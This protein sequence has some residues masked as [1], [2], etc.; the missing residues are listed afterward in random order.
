MNSIFISGI[1]LVTPLGN[2]REKTWS[3]LLANKSA[4]RTGEA[5]MEARVID[6][7]LNG[8]RSRMGDF[9]LLAAQDALD[10]AGFTDEDLRSIRVGCAVSQSKPL[11]DSMD[12]SLV[13]SSFFGWSA[14]HVIRRRYGF[15]GPFT[16]V[17][18]ACATGVASIE[19]GAAWISSGQCDVV[20]VGA[21]ESSLNNFYRSGFEKMGVLASQESGHLPRPFDHRR[22]GF[23][24]GEGAAVMVLES[25]ASLKRRGHPA[26]ASLKSVTLQHSVSDAIRFDAEGSAVSRLVRTACSGVT[27][28]YINAHGT[29]TLFNDLAETLGLKKAFGDLAYKIPISSTKAATGHLLGA[30][31]AVEAAF[32]VLALRDQKIPPTLNLTTPDP[33][34]DLDYVPHTSRSAQVD[35]AL[36]LSYGFGGQLGAVL[37]E[38]VS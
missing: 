33:Q 15:E 38:R 21:C 35:T 20:L 26:L 30:A 25:E 31:G 4:V 14:G 19:C 22:T 36:S 7:S 27:P 28:S 16:N 10:Q 11:L 23:V 18:A 34:C 8:A 6:F 2:G 17:V 12:P 5:G 1:G 29:G 37:F 13:M 9:A 3:Q 24:M 32:A